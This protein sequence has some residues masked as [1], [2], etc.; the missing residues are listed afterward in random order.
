MAKF[1][2]SEIFRSIEG[3]GP[4]TG[5]PTIYCR[6]SNCNFTC[7]G[8]NNPDNLDTES[9]KVLGFD[10][11]KYNRV[12]DIPVAIEHGCDTVY[13]WSRR[14]RHMW[15]TVTTDELI[16]EL[17][18]LLPKNSKGEPCWIHP[19]TGA[20]YMF[21][22]TG[23]EPTLLQ[24][25]LPDLIHHPRMKDCRHMLVETNCSL[26]IRKTFSD[27]IAKWLNEHPN[28]KWTWS[29]S[30]KLSISG[31]AWEEAIRP[32]VFVEQ[33][34]AIDRLETAYLSDTIQLEQYLKF[35]CDDSD[36]MFDEVA[37]AV[38]RYS[39]ALE[40][41]VSGNTVYIMPMAC[42][43]EQQTKIAMNVAEKCL[44]KGYTY[45]HRVHNDVYANAIGK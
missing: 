31:E 33:L 24:K 9:D 15:Q 21:S 32:N 37:R 38:N 7:K 23:G 35:V 6:F 28:R 25:T 12:G 1:T 39:E 40:A 30:P 14:F 3:E 19:T 22:I 8:F 29:N 26:D 2:Y 34:D 4:Y 17:E 18:K 43:G 13:S 42:T 16:D 11:S 27:S 10:P 20:E 44:D 45:C 41:P 5:K 36:E